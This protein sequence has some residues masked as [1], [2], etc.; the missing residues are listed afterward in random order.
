M[1]APLTPEQI[2]EVTALVDDY[3]IDS[4][5]LHSWLA[6]LIDSHGALRAEVDRYREALKQA[7]RCITCEG[8]G[9]YAFV[10]DWAYDGPN[11]PKEIIKEGPCPECGGSKIGCHVGTDARAALAGGGK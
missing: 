10:V 9:T 4:G 3:S 6:D 2:A 5:M 1:T 11:E 8:T 7:A